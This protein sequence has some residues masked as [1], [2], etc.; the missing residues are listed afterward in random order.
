MLE[1]DL[2]FIQGVLSFPKD[3]LSFG[4]D[5]TYPYTYTVIINYTIIN[6]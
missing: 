3:V 5:E 4:R 2:S 1:Y 6:N